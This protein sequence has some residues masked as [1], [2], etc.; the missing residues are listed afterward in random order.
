MLLIP[1]MPQPVAYRDFA[2]HRDVFG[3]HNF[4]DVASNG[5]FLVVGVFG[6]V[7]WYVLSK[8][9][10]TYDAKVLEWSHPVSCAVAMAARVEGSRSDKKPCKR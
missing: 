9:L 5:A 4:L 7:A 3:I 1:A 6:L 10:E 2:D 8:L